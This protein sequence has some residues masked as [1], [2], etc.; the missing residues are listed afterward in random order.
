MQSTDT[1][2][3]Y[4]SFAEF[5]SI[6]GKKAAA[7]NRQLFGHQLRQ[8][9]G[10]S[11]SAALMLMN[12]YGTTARFMDEL[13]LMGPEKAQVKEIRTHS[14]TK[15]TKFFGVR[16]ISYSFLTIVVFAVTDIHDFQ[17]TLANMSNEVTQRKLGPKLAQR[18]CQI[19]LTN[20]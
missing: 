15:T 9:Q 19:Y 1:E 12:K 20:F 13:K 8:I 16:V 5:Q 17:Y 10:C 3:T 7:T 2:D 4:Q 11:T 18:L 14:H 6:Y